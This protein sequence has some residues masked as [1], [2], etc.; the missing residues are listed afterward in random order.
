MRMF[1]KPPILAI[2]DIYDSPNPYPPAV[3]FNV[4]SGKVKFFLGD[5]WVEIGEWATRTIIEDG[6]MRVQMAMPNMTEFFDEQRLLDNGSDDW[7]M[8]GPRVN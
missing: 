6:K 4:E 7:A 2:E 5:R 8:W 3:D 1:M